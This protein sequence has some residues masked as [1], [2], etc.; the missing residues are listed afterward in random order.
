MLPVAERKWYQQVPLRHDLAPISAKRAYG[1][2]LFV[3]GCFF[4][5]SI[6]SAVISLVTRYRT[7][8]L[9]WAQSI[10]SS[11]NQIA[12]AAL[13]VTVPLLFSLR[14]GV[15]LSDFGLSR[16]IFQRP[17]QATRIAAWAALAIV[18]GAVVITAL[19]ARRF[20]FPTH[21]GP[22]LLIELLHSMQAGP[23]EEIVVLGFVVTTLQQARRPL[24]E[25]VAIALVLRDA[26]HVYYGWGAL[27]IF[28][29][30][31]IF[32]W[33][34]L[35]FRTLI[36]LI[37]VHSTWDVFGVLA[38]YYHAIGI[39][40]FLGILTLLSVASTTWIVVRSANKNTVYVS[41]R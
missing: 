39:V 19:S 6:S 13:A 17:A 22:N 9:T 37:I 24:W 2:V 27:G 38:Q 5:A 11:I 36:P 20:P 12:V 7:G 28:V 14:R 1:E 21:T 23:L 10:P 26:F 34:Y 25:V 3:Y 30:A 32:I 18:L 35:R 16:D 41:R 31:S 15:R 40:L 33:L 29:W 8:S 4:L